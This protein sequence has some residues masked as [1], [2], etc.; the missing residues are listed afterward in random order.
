MPAISRTWRSTH[1]MPAAWSPRRR[2]G[3]PAGDRR[4]GGL[5]PFRIIFPPGKLQ[6]VHTFSSRRFRRWPCLIRNDREA[7]AV[8]EQVEEVVAE[9]VP[10]EAAREVVAEAVPAE[11]ARE[12]VERVVAVE[13]V[14]GAP[15]EVRAAAEK[16]AREEAREEARGVEEEVGLVEAPAVV[17]VVLRPITTIR[18]TT[19]RGQS[20]RHFH[21][22]L[23]PTSK[24]W[25]RW[26][27]EPAA[28][29]F[30]TPT[31]C[32]GDSIASDGSKT[33]STFSGT[34]PLSPRK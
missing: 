13:A 20:C 2:A 25:Q 30:S 5:R 33:S 18:L 34:C 19:S 4:P 1:S 29:R 27:K 17:P 14:P 3:A 15:V 7:E 31:I 11:A 28:L 21:H 12:A 8:V 22:R 10:A 9:A 26:R 32:L 23:R 16:E 6:R 24:Y